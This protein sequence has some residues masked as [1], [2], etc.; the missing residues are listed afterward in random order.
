VPGL[1][2]FLTLLLLLRPLSVHQISVFQYAR[3]SSVV[4]HGMI[5]YFSRLMYF[6]FPKSVCI[7]LK[8]NCNALNACEGH[9]VY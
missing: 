9:F 7:L 8:I 6:M 3:V 4:L 5:I 1:S 2:D